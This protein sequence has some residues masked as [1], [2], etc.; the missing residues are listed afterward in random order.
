MAHLVLE[1]VLGGLTGVRKD[2]PA[3]LLAEELEVTIYATV[4]D[5]PLQIVRVSR[6]E[7]HP[8]MVV[9]HTHK[10][11]RFYLPPEHVAALKSGVILKTPPAGAGFRA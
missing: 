6:V 10:G 5:E 4:G 8:T 9:I 3:Y 2:G 7:I 1:G 11:E